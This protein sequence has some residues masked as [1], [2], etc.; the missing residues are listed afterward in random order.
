MLSIYGKVQQ[1]V[2]KTGVFYLV[3]SMALI[4]SILPVIEI[5][6]YKSNIEIQ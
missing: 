5:S 6:I 1:A 2:E 4:T 3:L